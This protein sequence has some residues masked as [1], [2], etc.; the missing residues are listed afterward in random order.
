VFSA[1]N[2]GQR[3]LPP[4]PDAVPAAKLILSLGSLKAPMRYACFRRGKKPFE[5]DPKEPANPELYEDQLRFPPRTAV[6]CNGHSYRQ[7][8]GRLD[9]PMMIAPQ[10][11]RS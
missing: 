3:R 11:T 7:H 2:A 10:H 1:L 5:A 6:E 8:P 9:A 4:K